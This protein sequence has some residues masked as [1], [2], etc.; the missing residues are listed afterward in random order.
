[1]RLYKKIDGQLAPEDIERCV[2]AAVSSS[3]LEGLNMTDEEIAKLRDYAYGRITEA[4]YDAWVLDR[5]GV[6]E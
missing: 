4:E 5:A 2:Q 1:M 6:K 3:R